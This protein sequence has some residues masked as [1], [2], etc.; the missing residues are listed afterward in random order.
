MTLHYKTARLFL[1]ARYKCASRYTVDGYI[2]IVFPFKALFLH[3]FVCLLLLA[4]VQVVHLQQQ[5]H[6]SA[7]QGNLLL[8]RHPPK[9]FF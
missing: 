6:L 9:F 7:V 2:I 4:S 8:A 1:A 3:Y 5:V